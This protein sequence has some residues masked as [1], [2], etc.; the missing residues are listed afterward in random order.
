MAVEPRM[1]RTKRLK[2]VNWRS[3]PFQQHRCTVA[4][5]FIRLSQ[6]DHM[7]PLDTVALTTLANRCYSEQIRTIEV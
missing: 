3:E 6:H 1:T 4:V 7:L 2:I 5:P